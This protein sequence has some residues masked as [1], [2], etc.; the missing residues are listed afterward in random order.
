MDLH[1]GTPEM[2]YK[3]MVYFRN[4]NLNWF[5]GKI[6]TKHVRYPLKGVSTKSNFTKA[7]RKIID[8]F[9]WPSIKKE[10]IIFCHWWRHP[11]GVKISHG[12]SSIWP[13]W[14]ASAVLIAA[15]CEK[16]GLC[17]E[18][19]SDSRAKEVSPPCSLCC[20]THSVQATAAA[21]S[22]CAK[23][24]TPTDRGS[25]LYPGTTPKITCWLRTNSKWC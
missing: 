12:T 11:T 23:T 3:E 18:W 7:A 22:S 10:H 25:K 20:S 2:R 16:S 24:L 6:S 15:T 14:K 13:L 19:S 1:T 9:C 17:Q 4:N 8:I 21:C 5:V